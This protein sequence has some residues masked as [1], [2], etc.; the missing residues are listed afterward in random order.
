MSPIYGGEKLSYSHC[1]TLQAAPG[2]IPGL[3]NHV[4]VS[5]A[6]G[7]AHCLLLT[8]TGTILSAGYNDRGQLGLGHRISTSNF[9]TVDYLE[10]KFVVQ[11]VCGQQH[12]MCRAIDRSCSGGISVGDS[13]GCP[14]Y[15][16]GNGVLGQLGLGYKGTSKGR[17]FPTLLQHLSNVA[18][19]GCRDISAGG[20]FS[21]AVTASGFVYSWGHAEYNQH[22]KGANSQSDYVDARYYFIPRELNLNGALVDKISCGTN[23]TAAV[24]TTGD[25]I[26]WGWSAYGVLGHGK[27]HVSMEPTRISTLG[28]QHAFR[29]VSHVVAGGQHV[30]ACAASDAHHWAKT[31][32]HLLHDTRFCDAELMDESESF[33][34]PCHQVVLA[35]R[36]IYFKSY[37][38]M[39]RR[40]GTTH[41]KVVIP[42]VEATQ[43]NMQYI[44]E[45]IY[46]DSIAVPKR[47]CKEV[48][49][50]ASYLSLH[51]LASVCSEL[52]A[53]Y[54]ARKSD[55]IIPP[56]TFENDM[57]A[58]VNN[59]L[60]ADIKFVF[61]LDEN[62]RERCLFAHK[63][64]LTPIPYFNTLFTGRFKIGDEISNVTIFDATSFADDLLDY[65]VLLSVL[66]FTY[67]GELAGVDMSNS[68]HVMALLL[69][70]NRLNLVHL[71]QKCE[72]FIVMHLQD[73][74]ENV[75]N[76]YQYACSYDIPR[77][78]LQCE[79]LLQ[80]SL[81]E[82]A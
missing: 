41:E 10:G 2:L 19:E 31:F 46:T 64:L 22:G 23:F 26:T 24:T 75:D 72:K 68:T 35:A 13:V 70:A 52:G 40:H 62:C 8:R 82:A 14:V 30:I 73:Y 32:K 67:T 78:R 42:F 3:N 29:K 55:F 9:K 34:L 25:V 50:L 59:E 39:A 56:T 77:L 4:V 47:S 11:I 66:Q 7:Y 63:A 27:G 45:Y 1:N 69:G 38:S 33:S 57:A 48:A 16:W 21:A 60:F 6:A 79:E 76:C 54:S 5:V 49:A 18:P 81:K 51:R 36:S 43:R 17:L 58:F 44:L 15:I 65:D 37:F 53:P 28:S 12:S 71:S 20:N 74:P 61:P 80:A